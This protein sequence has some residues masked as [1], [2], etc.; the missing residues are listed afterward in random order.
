M[1]PTEHLRKLLTELGPAL[2]LDG[3][4][5]FDGGT[6]MIVRDDETSVLAELNESRDAVILSAELGVPDEEC[7]LATFETALISNSAAKSPFAPRLAL[8][9]RDGAL[10]V[11]KPV[12][13]TGLSI[14]RLKSELRELFGQIDQWRNVMARG[15]VA[16]EPVVV[17]AIEEAAAV[18][19]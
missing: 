3:V 14:D 8:T 1:T 2:D 9:G 5:E 15:G 16:P 11:L 17:D 4:S 12:G 10:Q 19:V 13:V 6:W 7:R 18:R